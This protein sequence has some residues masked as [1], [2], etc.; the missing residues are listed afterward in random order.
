MPDAH[1]LIVPCVAG[2]P[3]ADLAMLFIGRVYARDL[4]VLPA[5]LH[6]EAG[7]EIVSAGYSFDATVAGLAGLAEQLL[8]EG[9]RGEMRGCR[10][11]TDGPTV[12]CEHRL[13][14]RSPGGTQTRQALAIAFIE[15]GQ[16]RR[17]M[18]YVG[19][20]LA[21]DD[22]SIA[23]EGSLDR[24]QL[25]R[26]TVDRYFKAVDSKDVAGALACFHEDAGFSVGTD[27]AHFH[28]K[29]EIGRMLTDYF[30]SFD[31]IEHKNFEVIVDVE[32]QSVAAHFDGFLLTD[33]KHEIHL[34]N[35]NVWHV[36]DG[37]FEKVTVYMS[38]ENV[39]N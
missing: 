32:R 10:I 22:A 27:D 16:I 4:G 23:K 19:P 14:V 33:T 1:R 6:S 39:L 15:D 26:L 12:A 3:A 29:G 17:A 9:G 28:G 21:L 35:S 11:V 31:R 18:F 36:R 37:L 30:A 34:H 25:L 24:E 8:P 13:L 2:L 5:M 7:L 38:G 20:E